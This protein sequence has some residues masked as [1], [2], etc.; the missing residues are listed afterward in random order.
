[1]YAGAID[2]G[3]TVAEA[4]TIASG[5]TLAGGATGGFTAAELALGGNSVN[6]AGEGALGIGGAGSNAALGVGGA[7]VAG[8]T[9]TAGGVGAGVVDTGGAFGTGAIDAGL[10]TSG[11]ELGAAPYITQAAQAAGVTL[12]ATQAAEAAAKLKA[13]ADAAAAAGKVW[14][15]Q[16]YLNAANLALTAG[17]TIAAIVD[18]G[19]KKVS[20]TTTTDVK[21]AGEKVIDTTGTTVKTTPTG[22]TIGGKTAGAL[23]FED[24]INDFYGLTTGSKSAQVRG[25]EDQTSLKGFQQTLLNSLSGLDATR[26]ADTKTAVAPFQTQLADALTGEKDKTGYFAPFNY[27]FGGKA[28]PSFVPKN[29]INTM[30]AALGVGRESAQVGTGLVDQAYKSGTDIA[31]RKFGFDS[32]NLPNKAADTYTAKLEALMKY[33]NPN[34]TTATTTGTVPGIPWYTTA[35]QGLTTGVSL[36]DKINNPRTASSLTAADLAAIQAALKQA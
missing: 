30:N 1:M 9:G 21:G 17:A 28:M 3:L 10:A 13:A 24:F 36:W 25:V 5:G 27:S 34:G 7:G 20:T 23:S 31:G 14:T 6:F 4:T 11:A 26:L 15:V 33:F 29:Q 18:A 22:T 2:A 19:D 16:N 35:L 8:G 32:E 12:S